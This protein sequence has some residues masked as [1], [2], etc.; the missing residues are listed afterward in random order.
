MPKA[1]T[2]QVSLARQAAQA[3]RAQP[4]LLQLQAASL[5]MPAKTRLPRK[6]QGL[7]EC[8]LACQAPPCG[9]H[10]AAMRDAPQAQRTVTGTGLEPLSSHLQRKQHT[11]PS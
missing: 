7:L 2:V 3:K 5:S 8:T 11:H 9:R 10:H 1:F 6:Q 4:Q